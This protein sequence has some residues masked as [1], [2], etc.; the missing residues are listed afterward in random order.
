MQ[1]PELSMKTHESCFANYTNFHERGARSQ[2]PS[3]QQEDQLSA[4]ATTAT[5]NHEHK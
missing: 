5:D 3:Y 1:S 4:V 2:R